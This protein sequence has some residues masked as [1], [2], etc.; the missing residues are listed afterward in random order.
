MGWQEASSCRVEV[1]AGRAEH[2]WWFPSFPANRWDVERARVICAGCPVA[3]E[4]REFAVANRLV[5]IWAG[6][7]FG[8]REH[9]ERELERTCPECG[10]MFVVPPVAGRR[11]ETCSVECGNAR[12]RVQKAA[13]DERRGVDVGAMRHAGHGLIKRYQQGC[14]CP[15]C[16]RVG[17]EA[18]ARY[19]RPATA[20]LGVTVQNL[21]AAARNAARNGEG[22][23]A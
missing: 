1:A 23:A 10:Q 21:P 13:A 8:L 14:K 11:R 4:C 22:A 3:G 17:R 6:V 2:S 18:R 15:A 19:R 12:H 5:G 20:G 9:R 16:R 7:A